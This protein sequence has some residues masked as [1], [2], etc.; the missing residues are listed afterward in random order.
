MAEGIANYLLTTGDISG[1]SFQSAGTLHV[2]EN[3][4]SSEA[5]KVCREKGIDISGHRSK[6]ITYDMLKGADLI[7]VM[8]ESNRK[9][10]GLSFPSCLTRTF[11]L[12]EYQSDEL[13]YDVPDPIGMGYQ[14]Y[15]KVFDIL[16]HHLTRI[17]KSFSQKSKEQ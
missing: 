16:Y 9:D 15:K 13:P 5:V 2:P 11:L 12:T 1:I 3:P 14:A 6:Q 10:I 17:I 4:P 8:A 7:L